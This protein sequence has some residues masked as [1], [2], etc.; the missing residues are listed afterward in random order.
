[1]VFVALRVGV[2]RHIGGSSGKAATHVGVNHH[3]MMP[4]A[5]RARNQLTKPFNG[6]ASADFFHH[7][8]GRVVAWRSPWKI[9]WI[10]ENIIRPDPAIRPMRLS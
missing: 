1:M 6:V 2:R 5:G 4:V 3:P 9:R 10:L 8:R 7:R